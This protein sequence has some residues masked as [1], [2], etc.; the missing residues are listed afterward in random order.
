MIL[1]ERPRTL[2]RASFL[3]VAH[4]VVD[5][6]GPAVEGGAASEV[7]RQYAARRYGAS[8]FVAPAAAQCD[9]P[10]FQSEDAAAAFCVWP[11]RWGSTLVTMNTAAHRLTRDECVRLA[12]ALLAYAR[13]SQVP[14]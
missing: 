14:E 4:T 2:P 12:L 9:R 8:V 10:L 6:T 7:A 11:T 5:I 3:V 1:V 13:T